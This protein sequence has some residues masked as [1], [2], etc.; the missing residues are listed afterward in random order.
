MTGCKVGAVH[1]PDL[2]NPGSG[3]GLVR[4]DI[5]TIPAPDLDV[6]LEFNQ[7]TWRDPRSGAFLFTLSTFCYNGQFEASEIAL[8]ANG[9]RANYFSV[10]TVQG[11]FIGTAE[12]TRKTYYD[13][14]RRSAPIIL[15]HFPK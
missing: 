5:V 15:D 3:F 9:W 4:K 10:I 8:R 13:L 1:N 12:N 6:P 14:I 7:Y 2:C 11:S